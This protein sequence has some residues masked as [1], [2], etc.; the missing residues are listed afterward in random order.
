MALGI[1]LVQTPCRHLGADNRCTIYASR[2][3]I[4]RTYSTTNCEYRD[5]WVYDQYWE[6]PEQ[7]EEYAEAVLGP[8][9]GRSNRSPR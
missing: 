6:T 8:R 5:D 7:V 2:P 9:N 1:L 4:C 3:H